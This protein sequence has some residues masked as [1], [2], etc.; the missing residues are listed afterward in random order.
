MATEDS[1][2]LLVVVAVVAAVAFI[3]SQAKGAAL[4]I[5]NAKATPVNKIID[6]SA[7]LLGGLI[8]ALTG[9]RST[10]NPNISTDGG[11]TI[12]QGQLGHTIGGQDPTAGLDPDALA[13]P[14]FG[15]DSFGD[16]LT[17]GMDAFE[18]L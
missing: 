13:T 1:G 7:G 17:G 9:H 10:G 11:Y 8:A 6:Q 18:D 12:S 16:D 4:G 2:R 5:A 3:A 14:D 15:G